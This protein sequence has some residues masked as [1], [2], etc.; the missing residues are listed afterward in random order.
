MQVARRPPPRWWLLGPSGA[1]LAT[2]V[3]V[4]TTR[5][6]AV[7]ASQP[8]YLV[9]LLVVAVAAAAGGTASFVTLSGTRTR[10]RSRSRVLASR[11]LGVAGTAVVGGALAWLRPLPATGVAVGSVDSVRTGSPLPPRSSHMVSVA[12][13]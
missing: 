13:E 10:E 7:R 11:I 2:A 6:G 9:T 12:D 4:L 8:A 5:W 1:A 3:A